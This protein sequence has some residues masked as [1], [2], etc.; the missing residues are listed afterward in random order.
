M[1]QIVTKTYKQFIELKLPIATSI[2]TTAIVHKLTSYSMIKEYAYEHPRSRPGPENGVDVIPENIAFWSNV[3]SATAALPTFIKI[4]QLVSNSLK[5][6]SYFWLHTNI[7]TKSPRQKYLALR[8]RFEYSFTQLVISTKQMAL[9]GM[10]QAINNFWAWL[11]THT[12]FV[13]RRGLKI[14]QDPIA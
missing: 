12:I 8:P 7:D 5:H 13:M 3:N 2:Y 1:I 10:K 11:R 4:N 14:L 9:L 6:L